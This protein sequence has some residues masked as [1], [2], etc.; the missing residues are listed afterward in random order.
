M[1]RDELDAIKRRVTTNPTCDFLIDSTK[2]LYRTSF[3]LCLWGI[4]YDM[5][6][7]CGQQPGD[8]WKASPLPNTY[9]WYW[10]GSPGWWGHYRK[11]Q[12]REI[13]KFLYLIGDMVPEYPEEWSSWRDWRIHSGGSLSALGEGGLIDAL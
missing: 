1:T 10:L 3:T 2:V 7:D 9:G 13:K 5:R 8:L 11:D 6:R 4:P 12:Q